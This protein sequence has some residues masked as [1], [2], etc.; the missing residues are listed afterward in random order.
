MFKELHFIVV[1]MKNLSTV[2][3]LAHVEPTPLLSSQ[4]HLDSFSSI[5]HLQIHMWN[6]QV[7]T[8][9]RQDYI[10]QLFAELTFKLFVS[11]LAFCYFHVHYGRPRYL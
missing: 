6:S 3:C 4:T 2:Y 5:Q 7:V 11:E 9:L 8:Y 10:L 1:L